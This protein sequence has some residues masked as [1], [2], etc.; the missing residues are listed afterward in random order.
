[1]ELESLRCIVRHLERVVV[2]RP[3]IGDTVSQGTSGH[4]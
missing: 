2:I 4:V 3:T 1:M